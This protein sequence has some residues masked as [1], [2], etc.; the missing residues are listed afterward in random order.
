MKMI[1]GPSL[2]LGH[3]IPAIG[4]FRGHGRPTF[5]AFTT[6]SGW[7]PRRECHAGEGEG[8]HYLRRTAI[9]ATSG[10]TNEV[11]APVNRIAVRKNLS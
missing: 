9:K 2:S 7:S 8:L 10:A 6:N 3:G 5:R 4:H 1:I 11:G